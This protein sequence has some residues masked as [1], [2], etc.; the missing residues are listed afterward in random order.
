M[1]VAGVN[2]PHCKAPNRNVNSGNANT[3]WEELECAL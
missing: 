1:C 2:L 3:K